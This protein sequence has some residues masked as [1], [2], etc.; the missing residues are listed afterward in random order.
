MADTKLPPRQG[1]AL[2]AWL[3]RLLIG[4]L[5]VGYPVI[6]WIGLRERSP[7]LIAAVL[8]LVMAPLAMWRLR[9]SPREA[10]RGLAIVP[11]VTVVVLSLS[12]LL[13][14]AGLL[15]VVPVLINTTFLCVF[16]AS[17]RRGSMPMVE[18]FARLQEPTLSPDKQAWC[19]LWTV[20]WCVFF[21]AN[22]STALVLALVAPLAWW[23]TYN[24][25]V[26]Y[27]L[28]GILFAVE[29]TL[30]RRRFSRG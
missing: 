2:G 17:L 28:I 15:L 1:R 12:L 13:D 14:A 11:I 20:I 29:W 30:R 22:A 21:V 9:Q 8:L 3:V 24:G 25:L 18:R 27:G 5:F 10:V 6:V 4:A 16:G 23:A 19:R 7:R 26:A